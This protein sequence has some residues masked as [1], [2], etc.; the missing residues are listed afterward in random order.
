MRP[1][2][3][4]DLVTNKDCSILSE[5]QNKISIARY[6]WIDSQKMRVDPLSAQRELDISPNLVIAHMGGKCRGE[7]QSGERHGGI[8]GI[9]TRLDSLGMIKG[10]FV[11]ERED[12]PAPRFVLDR[13]HS[14][15]DQADKDIGSCISDTDDIPLLHATM[16]LRTVSSQQGQTSQPAGSLASDIEDLPPVAG[17]GFNVAPSLQ[18]TC[19]V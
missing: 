12:E 10:Q 4:I 2:I 15:F 14:S 13:P 8:R 16:Q 19:V 3:V 1:V 17:C 5:P 7:T 18:A 6:A 9:P 11:T